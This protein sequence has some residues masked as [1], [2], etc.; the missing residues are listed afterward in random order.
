MRATYSW[1]TTTSVLV[2]SILPI[3]VRSHDISHDHPITDIY[4]HY[5]KDINFCTYCSF[6]HDFQNL[7]KR[8]YI[9]NY[10]NIAKKENINEILYTAA[11][12][13]YNDVLKLIVIMTIT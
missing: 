7:I 12:G 5:A 3:V 4:R 6:K 2:P 8:R 9:H 1:T 10:K 11:L 13:G